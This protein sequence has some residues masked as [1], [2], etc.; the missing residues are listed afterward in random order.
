MHTSFDGEVFLGG[1]SVVGHARQPHI[2]EPHT[3][4]DAVAP[5]RSREVGRR[6]R[7]LEEAWALHANA[8]NGF[9]AGETVAWPLR[10]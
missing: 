7:A 10:E 4:P 2:R 3:L 1:E 6:V 9:G 5:L 8:A